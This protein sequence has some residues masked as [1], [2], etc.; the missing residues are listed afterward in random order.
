MEVNLSPKVRLYIYII[1]LMGSA[2]IV[3]LNLGGVVSDLVMSV[4]SSVSG[5]ASLLAALNV[6]KK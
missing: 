1:V 5:A 4:W 3:P 6:T 2:I